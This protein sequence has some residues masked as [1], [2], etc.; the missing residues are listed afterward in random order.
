LIIR[1]WR[2]IIRFR[3][4]S[5]QWYKVLSTPG[6]VQGH[7]VKTAIFAPEDF[8]F[9]IGRIYEA[10]TPKSPQ[11]VQVFRDISEAKRWLEGDLMLP[12]D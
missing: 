1:G 11:T 12:E 6:G 9:G 2:I 3:I 4:K 7:A 5:D 8:P 10:L